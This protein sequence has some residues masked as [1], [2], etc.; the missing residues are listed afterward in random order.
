ML[1]EFELHDEVVLLKVSTQVLSIVRVT[2][3]PKMI[4]TRFDH[5]IQS[6]SDTCLLGFRC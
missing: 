4:L 1:Q 2:I 6:H 3:E 5:M